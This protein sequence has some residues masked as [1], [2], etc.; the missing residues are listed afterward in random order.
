MSQQ[1]KLS[2]QEVLE[3]LTGNTGGPVGPDGDGNINVVGT[4]PITVTGNPGTNTL[5]IE[6]DGTIPL[7][8]TEDTGTATPAANNLN[9]FGDATQGSVTSGAGDTITI[10]NSDASTSQKGVLET[11]TDAEAI[12]ITLD[13]V[14]IVPSNLGPL[15]A[16]PPPIGFLTPNTGKFTRVD[17]DNLRLDGNTLSSTNAN[18]DIILSPNG[19][20]TVQISYATEHA[21]AIY[22]ASGALSEVGPL[23]DGQLVIGSTGVAPVAGAITSTGGTITVSLGAGT[24]NIDTDGSIAASFPTDAG[25]ATP[26]A[27]ALTIAGGTLINTAGAASTVTINADDAVAASFPTDSGTGTPASNALTLTGGTLVSTSAVGSTVTIDAD[28]SVVASFPTDS[29][30]A[31]PSG[32][33]LTIAG[34]TNINTSGAGAIVTVNL[35]TNI[36]VGTI[37]CTQITIDPGA[38][39]D[40]FV[41][42]NINSTGE[43]RLGVDDDDG[44]AFKLSQGSALGTN[45]LIVVQPEG[46]T[47]ID[48]GT[49]TVSIEAFDVQANID[50][51]RSIRI[52]NESDTSDADAS[53]T[54]TVAGTSAGDPM[55]KWSVTGGSI[56]SAGVDNSNSDRWELT[57]QNGVGASQ[58]MAVTSVGEVT[59]PVTPAF[60]ATHSAAQTNVTGTGTN[61]TVNF[62]T[63]I[64][65]Q[66]SDYDGTNTFTA[67]VTGRYLF[68]GA[69][70]VNDAATSTSAQLNL[71][72]SN[73]GYVG[74][75]TTP[76][77]GSNY[78]LLV[79]VL[80]DMDAADTAIL[81]GVVS[82]MAGDTADFPSSVTNTYFSGSL[83]C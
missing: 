23:T 12:A 6:D 42:Y 25:T 33:A 41:Q 3:T 1:G 47:V 55:I 18:G 30:T 74:I 38:S 9:V 43:Y 22:G 66:N 11:A 81:Q 20:G 44:D 17:V 26:A 21:I 59:F 56:Y 4:G 36:S 58:A 45:D 57:L 83:Q 5:T 48:V 70:F 34:G 46:N 37:D 64:F 14:A 39:G 77:S 27:G 35:D 61:T 63:E 29:G 19:S 75:A 67:P 53:F 32:N 15:F 71:V 69:L 76:F 73:R 40:S 31:T 62:T 80:A 7:Q 65:D 13:N 51:E 2:E 72:T 28:G 60:L 10:T 16:S 54:A 50:A 82:G 78:Q 24:I 52:V 68:Q 8:F 49:S 79:T